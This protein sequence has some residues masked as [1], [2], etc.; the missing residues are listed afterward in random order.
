MLLVISLSLIPNTRARLRL[1]Q[2]HPLLT[3]DVPSASHMPAFPLPLR[4]QKRAPPRA[5]CHTLCQGGRSARPATFQLPTL[6]SAPYSGGKGS[7]G[8]GG[9]GQMACR[10][11][12]PRT[13]TSSPYLLWACLSFQAGFHSGHPQPGSCQG[14]H[15]TPHRGTPSGLTSVLGG[16]WTERPG[17]PPDLDYLDFRKVLAGSV[18]KCLKTR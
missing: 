10:Q 16:S 14:P 2:G 7:E 8:R 13:P 17:D 15:S 9:M 4:E 18:L 5:F 12:V 6:R 3:T 11:L 1:E